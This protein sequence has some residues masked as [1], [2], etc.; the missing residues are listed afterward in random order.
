[1]QSHLSTWGSGPGDQQRAIKYRPDIDGLRALAVLSVVAYHCAPG[2]MKSG[3]VGVDVFF[4]ISGYLIGTLV[5]KEI[6]ADSF[7][8]AEFYKRRARRILPALFG[9]L[10]FCY[11]VGLLIL[12]PSEL[13]RLGGEALSAI[14]SSSNF[15][16]WRSLDYF[17]PLS[18]L[19]PLLMTWSLG[20]EEQ[21]Y[22]IFPLLMLLM[23]GKNRRL[24]FCAIGVPAALSL[25]AFL[26]GS[27]YHPSA[28]FYL[29]PTRAWELASGVMLAIY[30]TNRPRTKSSLPPIALHGLSLL[31]FGLILLAT[32]SLLAG[33]GCRLLAVAGGLLLIASRD[34]VA[35]RALSWRPIVFIGLV[36]YSWYLWHWPMLSFAHIASGAPIS[37]LAGVTIGLVSF[38]CAVLSYVL[39]ERPFRASTTPTSQLFLRYGT[40][41]VIMM[42]PPAAFQLTHGLPQR[43]PEVGQLESVGDQLWSDT[44]MREEGQSGLPLDA[45]CVPPGQGRAIALIGDSHAAMIA[46]AL[47]SIAG[48]AAYRVVELAMAGCPPM[49][50]VSSSSISLDPQFARDCL[51]FQ[52][53]TLQYIKNDKSIQ[54]VVLAGYWAGAFENS[55]GTGYV[56]RSDITKATGREQGWA[57]AQIGLD[58]LVSQLEESGK[59]VYLVQDAPNYSFDPSQIVLTEDMRLRHEIARLMAS[60]IVR[61][62]TGI[63]PDL[64]SRESRGLVSRV[65][66][67]HPKARLIDLRSS[68]CASSS[69]EFARGNKT[70][71]IDTDHLSPLG[72]QIA[73]A[74]LHLR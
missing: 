39:V 47:R 34:G 19:K 32:T 27:I 64:D 41:A 3:Y 35:N 72:A 26:W 73:L 54:A 45:Q 33:A 9:V 56:D 12:S 58:R 31:G 52:D 53:D 4:V 23:R 37:A 48:Q 36:S 46:G 15:Y 14:T 44:C 11:V 21:F 57:L 29:L 13:A 30:E 50:G 61:Y 16:F 70:L 71:Y 6:C 63:A 67:A 5:Y 2:W 43:N 8:I 65:A 24:Q 59:S 18:S 22:L 28:T 1:M 10:L 49:S 51:A 17:H 69:C 74:G 25:L 66:A 68:L 38:C 62:S 20:V 7:S 40:V 55:D 42:A 60:P